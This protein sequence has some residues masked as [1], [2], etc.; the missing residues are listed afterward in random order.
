[1]N[2]SIK[3]VYFFRYTKVPL[4]D[5]GFTKLFQC[6]IKENLNKLIPIWYILH[7]III[8]NCEMSTAQLRLLEAKLLND[9]MLHTK[10]EEWKNN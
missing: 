8:L 6:Q 9:V 10:Y 5:A 7:I 1:M 2:Q 3:R 4:P